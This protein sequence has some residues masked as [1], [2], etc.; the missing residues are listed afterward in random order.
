MERW[1]LEKNP[2]RNIIKWQQFT[3]CMVRHAL[4]WCRSPYEQ[5]PHWNIGIKQ[6]KIHHTWGWSLKKGRGE[7]EK[8]QREQFFVCA[9]LTRQTL[10][11]AMWWSGCRICACDVPH[12]PSVD[13]PLEDYDNSCFLSDYCFILS[14]EHG[15]LFPISRV[16]GFQKETPSRYLWASK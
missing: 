3:T 2:S 14:K 7:E 12:I 10:V 16:S 15:T 1:S 9:Y 6:N 11:S 8:K 4:M 5:N 13:G